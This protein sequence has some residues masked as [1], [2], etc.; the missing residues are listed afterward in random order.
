MDL[1]RTLLTFRNMTVIALILII[2]N[3]LPFHHAR[4]SNKYRDL[5]NK[6]QG[7]LSVEDFDIPIIHS[8]HLHVFVYL[9]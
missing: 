3:G 2:V 9:L 4:L 7:I 6:D 8:H 5:I 1:W